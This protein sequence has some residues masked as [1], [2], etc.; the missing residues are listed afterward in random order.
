MPP[1]PETEVSLSYLLS[2]SGESLPIAFYFYDG[3]W[4]HL[5]YP[6]DLTALPAILPA[7]ELTPRKN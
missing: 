3:P 5:A 4:W 6:H 1:L 2:R 7:L